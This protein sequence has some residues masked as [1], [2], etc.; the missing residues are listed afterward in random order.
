VAI[1]VK[2]FPPATIGGTELATEKIAHYLSMAG[3]EVHVITGRLPG[4]KELEKKDSFYV[5]RI[6]RKKGFTGMLSRF[7]L[8]KRA[9]REIQPDIIHA[10]GLYSE[11]IFAVRVAGQLNIPVVV[12]PRGSDILRARPAALYLLS[13]LVL[14]KADLVL[15]QNEFMRKECEKIAGGLET[16]PLPNGVDSIPDRMEKKGFVLFVGRLHRVK[17]VDVLIEAAEKVVVRRKLQFLIVGEG[18]ETPVLRMLVKK[19]AIEEFVRFEGKKSGE[20]L[21]RLMGEAE[22][23]VLPSRSEAFPL[24]VVEALASGT[25]V[26]ASEVGG[27]PEIIRN[28]REGILVPPDDPEALAKAILSLMKNNDLRAEMAENARKRAKG[29]IW[30]DIVR[31]LIRYYTEV[32]ERAQF[33]IN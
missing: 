5:H 32:I 1:V 24:T 26:I 23:L 12:A 19:K 2:G 31:E 13:R 7:S 10:Q 21:Q 27:V 20:E 6:F 25:P 28:G 18:E 4:E 17:G 29:F 3:V 14:K 9:L 8:L 16:A 22:V 30:E 15:V 33:R 11:A